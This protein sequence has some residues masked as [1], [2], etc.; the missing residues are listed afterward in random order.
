MVCARVC[1]AYRVRQLDDHPIDPVHA[2]QQRLR[3]LEQHEGL[4][5]VVG[6]VAGAEDADHAQRSG[7]CRRPRAPPALLPVCRLN[8]SASPRPI[9][10]PLGSAASAS[11]EPSCIF[12]SIVVTCFIFSGTTPE[13]RH[14]LLAA[15]EGDHGGIG[16]HRRRAH[17]R[18]RLDEGQ[19]LAPAADAPGLAKGAHIA[20]GD[21]T[22]RPLQG[23]RL[24]GPGAP[25]RRR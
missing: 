21:G 15:G 6:G 25:R 2:A 4:V 3:A 18:Q 17:A 24:R 14:A 19:P 22:L 7:C 5:L 10:T 12:S 23:S 20:H 11:S 9:T 13:R 1:A 16:Q 8:L